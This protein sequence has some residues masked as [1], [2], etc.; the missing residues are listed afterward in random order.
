[1]IYRIGICDKEDFATSLLENIIQD[2]FKDTG[3]EVEVYTWNYIEGFIRDISYKVNLDILFIDVNMMNNEEVNVSEY[4]RN[5]CSNKYMY[6]IYTS[7]NNIFKIEWL[8]AHPFD[9]LVKPLNRNDVCALLQN[10]LLS[11]R[12]NNRFFIYNFNKRQCCVLLND[13]L[14]L[15]SDKKNIVLCLLNEVRHYMGCLNEEK[16][17]LTD[18]FVRIG[19]SYVI[20]INHIKECEGDIIT[21]DNGDIL[22]VSRSYKK[23]FYLK[24]REYSIIRCVT[25]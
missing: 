13:I 24:I 2:F 3:D 1:M 15:K 19:Q 7:I 11:N 12:K 6:T 8:A 16:N 17:K 20:N 18:A 4:I 14:Y 25:G 9:I 23:D 10:L 5:I 22:S 21:M